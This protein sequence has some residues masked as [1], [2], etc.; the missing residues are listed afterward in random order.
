[1]Y[2]FFADR[3]SGYLLGWKSILSAVPA[4]SSRFLSIAKEKI[5]G[6]IVSQIIINTFNGNEKL[7]N[8]LI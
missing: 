7:L 3:S 1:M 8:C 5:G 4:L 2:N 6:L